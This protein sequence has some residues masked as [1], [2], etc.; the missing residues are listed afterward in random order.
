VIFRKVLLALV[1]VGA[2]SMAMAQGLREACRPDVRKFC[3]KIPQ[4][5]GHQAFESCL[6]SNRNLI[7]AKCQQA[8]HALKM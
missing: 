6:I 4:S 5:L 1:F 3:Y 7:S 2:S 8:L